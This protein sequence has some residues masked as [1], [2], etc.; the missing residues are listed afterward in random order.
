L[1]N[2]GALQDIAKKRAPPLPSA[3]S[4]ELAEAYAALMLRGLN[5]PTIR[6]VV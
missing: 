4:N 3:Y 1:A 2:Q 6:W 5:T